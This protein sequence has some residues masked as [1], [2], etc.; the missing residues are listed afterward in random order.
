MAIML[1]VGLSLLFEILFFLTVLIGLIIFTPCL[2]LYLKFT[3]KNEEGFTE[4]HLR[5]RQSLYG[6]ECAI[7]LEEFLIN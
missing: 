4:L 2:C 7:C 6:N 1:Y 3:S 5:V